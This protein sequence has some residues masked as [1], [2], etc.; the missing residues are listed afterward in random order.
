MYRRTL[1]VVVAALLM[2]GSV[3]Y[4]RRIAWK[5]ADKPPVS[6]ADAAKIA[7]AEA[8]KQ[9]AELFCIDA[10]LAKT[11]TGGDWEFQYSSAKGTQFWVSVGSDKS[12]RT[13]DMGFEY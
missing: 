10:S 13:S 9:K 6:L 3:A 12:V 1:L 11:F 2:L 8:A 4:A 5:S 7:D